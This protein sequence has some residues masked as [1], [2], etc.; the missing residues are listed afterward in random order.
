[1]RERHMLQVLPAHECL[2]MFGRAATIDATFPFIGPNWMDDLALC[3]QSTSSAQ[4]VSDMGA[5]AGFLLDTCKEHCLTPNLAAGKT[6][7]STVV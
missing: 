7:S 5:V 6:E 2:P 1:M 3:V 4:L